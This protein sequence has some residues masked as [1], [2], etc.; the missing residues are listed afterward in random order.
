MPPPS[1]GPPGLG[2][3]MD[4][5]HEASAPGPYLASWSSSGSDLLPVANMS[6]ALYE[7]GPA[8]PLVFG[9]S[10]TCG[11][12]C[13]ETLG[14]LTAQGAEG[15]YDISP[16]HSPPPR[17][18]ASLTW[19]PVLGG[20]LLFGGLGPAGALNDTWLYSRATGWTELFPSDSPSAR[21]NAAMTYDPSLHAVVLFG[22]EGPG[23][24]DGGTWTFNGTTWA[25]L[26]ASPAP[27]P[28]SGASLLYDTPMGRIVLF[29]GS[30]RSGFDAD[31]WTFN[32]T[33]WRDLPLASGP[34]PRADAILVGTGNGSPLLY[35]GVGA[36][37]ALNDTWFLTNGSWAAVSYAG[38]IGPP[39]LIGPSLVANPTLGPNFYVL[40]GGFGPPSALAQSWN[41]YAPF[42]GV[43]NGTRPL[44][45]SLTTSGSEG[46]APFSVT[47]SATV[48]GGEAP[49]EV[50]W[51]FD[52]GYTG[53]GSLSEIHTFQSPGTY[54]VSLLVIDAQ[55]NR[56]ETSVSI[57]VRA[58][59]PPSLLDFLG[60]PP[61]WALAIV[62]GSVSAWGV[63]GTVSE[64]LRG[65]RLNRQVGSPPSRMARTAVAVHRFARRPQGG[66]LV[67]E[68]REIWW[69][70]EVA[71]PSRWRTSP[72]LTWL[73]RR[74]LV[75]VPQILVGVTLLYFLTEVLPTTS[76]LSSLPAPVPFFTGLGAFTQDLFTGNW[77]TVVIGA[78]RAFPAT[79][80]IRYYLPY[81]L[82]LAFPALLFTALVSY[83]LGLYSGW[84]QGR[85]VDNTTRLF[86]AFA[87]F[88]PLLILAL[89]FVDFLYGPFLHTF[90]DIPFGSLPSVNWFDQH[91]GGVPGWVGYN[92]ETQPTG[93]P[94]IDAALHGAWNVEV[95]LW[96]KI[97]LQ[98]SIIGLAYS[99]LYLR[100]ARLAATGS[101]DDISV[102]ASRSRGT[103]EHRLLWRETSRKVLPIYVFTF[104]NTF[105]LFIL[106][107]S[108]VEWY[109]ADIGVGSFLV[110]SALVPAVPSSAP[111]LLA[112]LAFLVLLII[113][114][115][116]LAADAVSRKLDPRVGWTSRRD[117]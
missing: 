41:L 10:Y 69:T 108:L 57:V 23:G 43:P 68:L 72:A 66:T 53:S 113:L 116:N 7:G 60:G 111:P 101:R 8:F 16:A 112:V 35:G 29:G 24:P 3:R 71:L 88:F 18:E 48:Q 12:F 77:G 107:Q 30:G 56:A 27:S 115:V 80:L 51:N 117:R 75:T 2:V 64:L 110:Q 84:Q 26:P 73:A 17:S 78:G 9:G 97:A 1:S 20:A 50:S 14:Y 13:N 102:L 36:Q 33:A 95:L 34:S 87:A 54:A 65:R 70:R 5:S 61:V 39:P 100:Y 96:V 85:S 11:R 90:G 4:G 44:T 47:F 22:G 37:G 19:D 98:S 6:Y 94:V 40:M 106:V 114:T 74:L 42:G 109:F 45:A 21:Y 31:S 38:G 67:R 105:A 25:A 103:S 89:Y 52:D 55:G 46:T 28:R 91:Y 15:W 58:P 59:P 32:G 83:P 79:E 93:F 63:E 92:F 99:A 82:E 81:S 62:L 76:S 104:G 86:V 49:Y